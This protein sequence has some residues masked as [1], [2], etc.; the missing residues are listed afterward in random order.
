MQERRKAGRHAAQQGMTLT[1]I[2]VVVIIMTLIAT[3]VATAVL[4]ALSD[5]KI[6]QTTSDVAIV[7]SAALRVMTE[8]TDGACPS[9]D[10]LGLDRGA[11]QT[12]SWDRPFRLECDAEGPIVTSAGPDGAFETDDDIRAPRLV[13]GQP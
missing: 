1:E 6:R 7:R 3:A 5:A 10:E 13:A 12:D 11:R 8:R 4:P 2:M 9:F